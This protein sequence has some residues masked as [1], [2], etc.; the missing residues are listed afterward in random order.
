MEDYVVWVFTFGPSPATVSVYIWT[1]LT[2]GTCNGCLHLDPGQL[3]QHHPPASNFHSSQ[4][5]ALENLES[6]SVHLNDHH[7]KQELHKM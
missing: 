7:Q 3:Q 2:E 6:L 5:Q 1:Q 4:D